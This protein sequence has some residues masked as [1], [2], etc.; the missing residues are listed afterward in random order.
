LKK[1]GLNN[2]YKRQRKGEKMDRKARIYVVFSSSGFFGSTGTYK[3]RYPE[4]KVL[5][6]QDILDEIKKR[7]KG[8]EFVGT[9]EV[10]KPGYAVGNIQSQAGN[11]DG[12]LYF[13]TLPQEILDMDIPK[14]AVFPL[15]SQWQSPYSVPK[16]KRVLTGCIP[17][18]PDT[19]SSVFSARLDEV[20]RKIELVR[21]A[22]T[23]KSL[24]ILE[25]TDLM[26]LGG[27]EPTSLQFQ[28]EGR[29]LYEKRYI[30]NL[31]QLGAN[32]TVRPQS[33]MFA[34]M[35][36]IEGKKAKEVA[37]KWMEE[38]EDIVGTNREE[39][40][41]SAKLY[42]T[43]KE[44]MKEYG[45]NAITT[46]GYGA[47]IYYPGGPI[48]SQGLPSS[49]FCTDGVIATS[50]TLFDSLVTQQLG[51]LM[52]GFAGLNGDYV[53]DEG[54]NKAYI[55]HCECPFNDPYHK[56]KNLPFVIRNLPQ[57]PVDQ[58][59]KGGACVLVRL[60]ANEQVTVV[61]FSVHDKKMSLFSGTT[62]DGNSLFP[63]WDH[64]LCRTKAAVDTDAKA[65]LK[66]LDWKTFGNHRVVF[67][68]D[69]R[70]QFKDMAE[71]MGYE[72]VEK[73]KQK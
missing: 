56:G 46:E 43:M 54:N 11:L 2:Y 55:G 63:G 4:G 19:K 61:K 68:G 59:E 31:H 67:F 69:W 51:L 27:Y 66:N 20:A 9:T 73:D 23:L 49:Q 16:G 71:L 48:P 58:Q 29:A 40:T 28:D 70:Q 36:G 22:S 30:D 52:T 64:I 13:G 42:L 72:V 44:M 37:E 25:V 39:I 38:A 14:I 65:L 7:C 1:T 47:F 26:L 3:L 12:I 17:I 32:I 62:V 34:K 33:E 21:I 50:E 35:D 24:N 60:P 53:I 5:T 10:E 45:C 8:V 57:Y 41:K 18:I 15:W 6:N